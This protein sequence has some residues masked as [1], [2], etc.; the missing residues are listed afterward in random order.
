MKIMHN[1]EFPK[2]EIVCLYSV[3]EWDEEL[4]TEWEKNWKNAIMAYFQS[5]TVAEGT[6]GKLSKTSGQTNYGF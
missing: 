5:T 3:L 4:L 2:P 6:A 1:I